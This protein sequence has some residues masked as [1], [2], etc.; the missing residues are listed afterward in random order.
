MRVLIIGCGYVGT[1]LGRELAVQGHEV[2]GLTRSGS[3]DAELQAAGI[4]PV[5]GDL[6]ALE[7]LPVGPP[8]LDWVVNCAAPAGGSPQDYE[9]LYLEGNR[10]LVRWLLSK[11]PTRLLYTS[12]T[13][14]YGQDDGS[15][16]DESSPTEPA[17]ATGRILVAAENLL[18]AT[19]DAG[20]IPAVILRVAGIYG[21]GRGYWLRQFLAGEARLEGRGERVL[22]MI[23][24]DDVV[25]AVQCAL[26]RG[27]PGRV[28]NATDHEPVAQIDLFRWLATEL[29]RPLPA[30]APPDDT[31]GRRRGATHKRVLNHRLTREL[32]YQFRF[33]TFREGFRHELGPLLAGAGT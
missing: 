3:R 20:T 15:E 2:H 5:R 4:R 1:A 31:G 18:R 16:V 19:A 22:N 30:A 8:D 24:R 23:H 26:V 6:A 27:L 28:Y 33:P 9:T 10:R 29:G 14:V 7:A 13:G 21:P 12:S 17:T 11:P 25:G 32:G